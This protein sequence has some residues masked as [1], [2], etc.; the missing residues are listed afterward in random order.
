MNFIGQEHLRKRE[1]RLGTWF[2]TFLLK[3][4][5][6]KALHEICFPI[7]YRNV[8]NVIKNIQKCYLSIYPGMSNQFQCCK[9]SCLYFCW[10]KVW[11]NEKSLGRVSLTI[12]MV[13]LM[14]HTP[15]LVLTFCEIMFKDTK[16]M[17]CEQTFQVRTKQN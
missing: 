9:N 15:K 14:C 16:V 8:Q 6:F 4:V 10:K 1:M 13:Y 7:L 5:T 11:N 2:H 17:F 12:V 3:N